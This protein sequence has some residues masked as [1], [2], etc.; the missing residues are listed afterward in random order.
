M[1]CTP[2]TRS[3]ILKI[4]CLTL[5]LLLEYL[6]KT[7]PSY[8]HPKFDIMSTRCACAKIYI[9]N[10]TGFFVC[11]STIGKNVISTINYFAIVIFEYS[12]IDT[13]TQYTHVIYKCYPFFSFF[14]LS[15]EKFSAFRSKCIKKRRKQSNSYVFVL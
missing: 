4:Y 10:K 2:M 7:F 14:I 9:K 12:P 11:V 15:P 1:A 3:P 5:C 13:H 6:F 8:L